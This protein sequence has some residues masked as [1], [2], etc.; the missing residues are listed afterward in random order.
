MCYNF[1][2][3]LLSYLGFISIN[4]CL[5]SLSSLTTQKQHYFRR[6]KSIFELSRN[7]IRQTQNNIY[8]TPYN[9]IFYFALFI[10][11]SL[12]PKWGVNW[13]N[14]IVEYKVNDSKQQWQTFLGL[15]EYK[16]NLYDWT[17]LLYIFKYLIYK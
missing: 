15:A 13:T 9:G 14:K 7:K 8:N 4:N 6:I 10:F 3:L 12:P 16:K 5:V 11:P 1:H 2:L 17:L